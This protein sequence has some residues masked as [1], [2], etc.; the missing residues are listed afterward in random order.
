MLQS[1]QP[2]EGPIEDKAWLLSLISILQPLPLDEIRDLARRMPDVRLGKGQT[3][4]TSKYRRGMLFLLLEGQVRLYE[5]AEGREFTLLVVRAGEIF[6]EMGLT[7]RK[8]QGAYAQ[9]LEPSRISIMSRDILDRT[10]LRR[11]EVGLRMVDLLS[12]RAAYYGGRLADIGIKDVHA[13]LAGLILRLIESEGALVGEEIK[14]STRYTH[15]QLGTM[16]GAN[17]EAVTNALT[18][19]RASGAITTKHRYI[20]VRDVDVLKK[21]A[22][23]MSDMESEY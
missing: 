6:G 12:E 13:R 18:R 19:L 4:Y 8:V 9:A 22:G 15:Y 14:I 7:D 16:I 10:V 23:A 3:L 21:A 20:H 17:R 11:P 2:E 5:V 1:E